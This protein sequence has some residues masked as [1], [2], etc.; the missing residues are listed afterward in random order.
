MPIQPALI[1]TTRFAY[2][3]VQLRFSLS[4]ATSWRSTDVDFDNS[5]FYAAIL[6]YFEAAPGPRSQVRVDAL[7][8]WW[9]KSVR[10]P[11]HADKA[12]C[13]HLA[14]RCLGVRRE[15]LGQPPIK[16]ACQY[17]V[18]LFSG[19]QWSKWRKRRR[20]VKRRKQAKRGKRCKRKKRRKRGKRWK[21]R[22]D[23]YLFHESRF[24][25]LHASFLPVQNPAGY[26]WP[27][28][29]MQQRWLI[30]QCAADLLPLELLGK[31]P[32]TAR[33]RLMF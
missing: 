15:A 6:D 23:Y 5:E 26:L 24:D 8:V 14:G 11:F 17:L 19:R 27:L 1:R 2:C 31:S 25:K 20:R 9:N 4:S 21:R 3:L 18:W 10:A 32:G 7:L 30:A 12:D 29:Q 33:E 22:L 28:P 13:P 16:P